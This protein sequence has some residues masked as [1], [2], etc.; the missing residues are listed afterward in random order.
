M[1]TASVWHPLSR[2]RLGVRTGGSQPSNRGSN[3]RTGT[4][5]RSRLRRRLP[6]VARPEFRRAKVGPNRLRSEL[7]LASH[8]KDRIAAS[9]RKPS[10]CASP[11]LHGCPPRPL[12]FAIDS[13][14]QGGN[15][16]QRPWL[17]SANQL[18]SRVRSAW[19]DACSAGD[20][21]EAIRVRAQESGEAPSVLH[22]SH[23]KCQ[24]TP[25]RAQCRELPTHGQV[26]SVVGRYGD[27]VRRR[28]SRRRIRTLPEIRVRCCVCP[29][30]PAIVR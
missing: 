20:D 5:L 11:S 15:F 4:N 29:T 8:T 10:E 30:P 26:P 23:L 16:S 12:E 9:I 24:Q 18:A 13:S 17:R 14:G 1:P 6:T 21:V 7:R 27:R 3:P 2:Y 19:Q 22:G 25:C 28:T